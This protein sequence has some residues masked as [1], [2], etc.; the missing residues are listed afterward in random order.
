MA[1]GNGPEVPATH[2]DLLDRPLHAALTTEMPDG[3]FQSTVVWFSRVG[4]DLLVNTMREFQKGRNLRARPWA[5]LLV[6]EPADGG[7]WIEV[8]GTVTIDEA[9]AQAHLDQLAQAYVGARHY[10]GEVVPAELAD[11]EHPIICRFHPIAI[12]TGP[13]RLPAHSDARPS[14][15]LPPGARSCDDDV[16]LPASHHDLLASPLLAA[17]TTRL[18]V[19][20]QTHP[21]WFSVDG[22]DVL[23]NTTLE[24][25]K[26]RNLV[27]DPRA[28]VLIVDP[29][30]PGRWIEIRGD[31]DLSVDDA[32]EHLD[33]LTRR[34]TRFP[35]FY[36]H[37]YPSDRRERETRVI[38]R[39]HPRRINLDAIH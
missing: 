39:I 17:L 4:D 28:T 20:A 15:P 13:R 32:I 37:V 12:T 5:T 10:F 14:P 16:A 21:V 38:A 26:G 3:T 33:G 31:V 18:P 2:A 9:G 11:I 25:S 8:R 23:I 19:G 36:G 29:D 34:Y 27:L 6:T 1:A 35:S 22:N 7:R 30:D 24:R